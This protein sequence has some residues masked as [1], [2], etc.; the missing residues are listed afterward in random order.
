MIDVVVSGASGFIGSRL[1]PL[2]RQRGLTV[3]TDRDFAAGTDK[4]LVY[5]HLANVHANPAANL[6]LLERHMAAADGRIGRWVQVQSFISLSGFGRLDGTRHNAG[7]CPWYIDLYAAGKLLQED[8]VL[9]AVHEGALPAATLIYLPAVIDDGGPWAAVKAQ[10]D[11]HGYVL[12]GGIH[13]DARANHVAIAEIAER[14]T[15]L[16]TAQR[17]GGLTPV[18][19]AVV[20][21]AAAREMT[22]EGF[23]GPRRLTAREAPLPPRG[24]K[25]RLR[26]VAREGRCVVLAVLWHLGL[27]APV[28][29]ALFGAAL[30]ARA[31]RPGDAPMPAEPV[32]FVGIGA[33]LLRRQPYLSL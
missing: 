19:R 8:R 24:L 5:L 26:A 29:K 11:T 27:L 33:Y 10:A 14:V 20:S 13:D 2:L 6:T 21:S 17:R 9:R 1:V 22:W 12:P 7:F 28:W 15:A 3:A 18:H 23:F 16:V 31:A 30:P 25:K 4:A 32:R